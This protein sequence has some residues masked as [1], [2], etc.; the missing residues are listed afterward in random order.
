MNP[1]GTL[2]PDNIHL[3]INWVGGI[4]LITILGLFWYL[5]NKGKGRR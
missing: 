4:V 2:T 1:D 3:L 5:D